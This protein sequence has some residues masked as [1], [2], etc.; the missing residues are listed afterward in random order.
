MQH[1]DQLGLH[2]LGA[3]AVGLVDDEHV[4][5]LEQPRLHHLHRVARLG[6]QD[7]HDR[8]GEP[9]DVELGL[10]DA[11]RLDEDVVHAEGVEQAHDVARRARQA[12]VR[13]RASTRLRMK[14]PGIEEVR[15]HA[16]A[17]A[18]HG[19]A[20]ER[21]RRIDRDDADA[22]ARPRGARRS[23]DRPASTCRRPAVR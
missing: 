9:H 17:I 13:C 7:D 15:L 16:D 11:D 8:V 18:E 5:D 14:T 6:H 12:A 4:G 19:A 10:P 3:V 2:A 1:L 21:A 22:V 20:G 23:G